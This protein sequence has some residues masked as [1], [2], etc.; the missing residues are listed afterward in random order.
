MKGFAAG[1]PEVCP[2][3]GDVL[4]LVQLNFRPCW[5]MNQLYKNPNIARLGI[6]TIYELLINNYNL[7][8]TWFCGW[9]L[10]ANLG[11]GVRSLRAS[12]D[13]F[14]TTFEWMVH[15]MQ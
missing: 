15:E 4:V 6:S 10:M 8:R 11:G 1:E 7:T 5:P 3:L 14:R 2:K 9:G 12:L 13:L